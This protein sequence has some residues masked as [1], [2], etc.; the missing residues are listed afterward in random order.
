VRRAASAHW[1]GG[2]EENSAKKVAIKQ[3]NESK[4]DGLTTW[5]NTPIIT[6]LEKP[7]EKNGKVVKRFE[8]KPQAN[9]IF[10]P[11]GQRRT[12]VCGAPGSGKTFSVID[13]MIRSFINQ[14]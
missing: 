3:I 9:T 1:A 5:I 11:D 13:P 10:I 14:D 12:A 6:A 4:R 2:V 8:I 7:I